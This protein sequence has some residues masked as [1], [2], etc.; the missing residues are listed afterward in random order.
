MTK[1]HKEYEKKIKKKHRFA[2]TP[3]YEEELRTSIEKDFFMSVVVKVFEKLEWD[4]VYQDETLVEAKCKNKWD[5]WSEKIEVKFAYGKIKV[6]STTLDGSIWD[7]G[8]NSKRVKLFIHV[9]NETV[10]SFD[11]ESLKKIKK[12][13]ENVSNWD[14]YE[15]PDTLP[16]PIKRRK[17]N[18][19]IPLIGGIIIALILGLLLAFVSIKGGYVIGLFE[20]IIAFIVGFS[21]KYLIKTGNYT[22]YDNLQKLLIGMVAI[23]FLSNQF[24]QYYMI[25]NANDLEGVGFVDF[26][27]LRIEQGLK[28]KDIDT[29]W[30]GLILSWAFQIWF[31]YILGTL[32]LSNHLI[33]YQL[34]RVPEEVS[35]F[36]FYHFIKGKTEQQV[37]T[38]LSKKG[39]THKY[40]QDAVFEAI[41]AIQYAV[42]WNRMA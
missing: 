28:L 19:V 33:K 30:I 5:K 23:I 40:D 2:W 42:D 35:D 32:N 31:I 17:S 13:V 4:I 21:L 14:D 3:K 27:K 18:F 6:K 22:D 20:F 11:R 16:A 7:N 29:G 36:A 38:E 8:K 24:F 41:G 12:E 37:R 25:V 34:E 9:F 39:W 26:M 10:K 15:I 1:E